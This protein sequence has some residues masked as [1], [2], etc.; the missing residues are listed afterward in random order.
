M[1]KNP[2]NG[3]G[4]N[5]TACGISEMMLETERLVLRNWLESDVNH[6]LVLAHD[7]G[8]NCFSPPG[9]FLV[10]TAEEAHAKVRERMLL[11][12]DRKL[13]KF[14]IFLRATG[15]FI[16]TC[17][18]EP[19]D[20]EERSEVE[21]GY[22]LCLNFWGRGYA[23]EAAAAILGYGFGD[24]KLARIMAFVLP[25]NKASVRILDQLG[26]QY[27][28]DF[29]HADLPHRLYEFPQDRFIA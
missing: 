14:P 13:G 23:R 21:L 11:F 24:L 20:L 2:A 8:Y 4:A 25:Q 12:H 3:S 5:T 22:R 10:H 1:V 27:L 15:E 7:V 26:F 28:R 9:R 6:Y 29:M 19:F 16:G 17:G 18:M